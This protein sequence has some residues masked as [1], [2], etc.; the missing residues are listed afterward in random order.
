MTPERMAELVARWVRF[1]TRDL[2]GSIAKRRINEIDADVHDH[3]AHERARG[4]SDRRIVLSILSRMVRGFAADTSWRG[5]HAKA[6]TAHPSLPGEAP[7][8]QK[9][10]YRSVRGVAL[11]TAFILLVPLL[12][13]QFTDEVAWGVVD[14][15]VAGALLGGTGLIHQLAASKAGNIAYRAAVGVALAAALLLVWMNL[16]VGVIGEPDDLANMMYVGVLA[17]GI[18]GA[19]IARFRP[20]GMGRAL[21]ATA[22]AQA[23]VAAIALIAGKHQL[24]L[25]SVS[26]ILGLNGLFVALFIGSAWLFRH[27]ARKQPTADAGPQD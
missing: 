4:T 1:Y 10:A 19:G 6:I 16:A 22:I 18:I 24:P 27:A 14:F 21:L 9:T 26:E 8:K 7:R 11:V 5:R 12:A 2:P 3:I 25:S 17:I 15:A 23:L 20:N 13:M